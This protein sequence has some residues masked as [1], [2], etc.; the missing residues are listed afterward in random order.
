MVIWGIFCI[1]G[2]QLNIM[3]KKKYTTIKEWN[4]GRLLQSCSSSSRRPKKVNKG[5]DSSDVT[6]ELLYQMMDNQNWKCIET[7]VPFLLLETRLTVA[8]TNKL[9]LNR[10]FLPSVDRL[11]NNRGYMMDNIQIVCMGYNN[12]KNRYDEKYV[13][14]WISS[15]KSNK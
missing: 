7:G 9:G 15:I 2:N 5:I 4:I 11:D 12:A 13:R 1:F 14:E 3:S 10:F 6:F 8:E